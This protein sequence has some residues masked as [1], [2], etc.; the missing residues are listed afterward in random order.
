[1]ILL[2]MSVIGSLWFVWYNP[3]TSLSCLIISLMSLWSFTHVSDYLPCLYSSDGFLLS[4]AGVIAFGLFYSMLLYGLTC[5][6]IL[7]YKITETK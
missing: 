5:L 2:G 1:M 6:L 3:V 4:P 7:F